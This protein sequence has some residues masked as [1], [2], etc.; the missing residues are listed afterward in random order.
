MVLPVHV[1]I[2]PSSWNEF[3]ITEPRSTHG[4]TDDGTAD[5]TVDDSGMPLWNAGDSEKQQPFHT[6]YDG[7]ISF[8]EATDRLNLDR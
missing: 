4:F 3:S 2:A 7:A 8:D 5:S 6:Q 1:P